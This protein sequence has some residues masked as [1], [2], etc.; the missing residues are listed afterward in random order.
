MFEE[1]ITAKG[2]PIKR[3]RYKLKVSYENKDYFRVGVPESDFEN[4]YV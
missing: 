3:A 2:T 4:T 1:V